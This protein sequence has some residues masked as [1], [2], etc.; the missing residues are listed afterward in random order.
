MLPLNPAL[1][2]GSRG[3]RDYHGERQGLSGVGNT[4]AHRHGDEVIGTLTPTANVV[5]P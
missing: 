1:R 4:N 5:V 2:Q 3:Y